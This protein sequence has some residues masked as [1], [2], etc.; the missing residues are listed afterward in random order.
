MG[1]RSP[2]QPQLPGGVWDAGGNQ[3]GESKPEETRYAPQ[4]S[5]TS[6]EKLDDLRMVLNQGF[7]R[8]L[9][10][11]SYWTLEDSRWSLP[12]VSLRLSAF[13]WQP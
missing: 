9:R 3:A 4:G 12:Q 5:I 10:S 8:R 7:F 1:W 11:R 2:S 6:Y 13:A